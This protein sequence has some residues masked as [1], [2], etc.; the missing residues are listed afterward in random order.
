MPLLGRPPVR[1]AFVRLS[2]PRSSWTSRCCWRCLPS[3]RRKPSRRCRSV[4]RLPSP[5]QTD[6]D[7]DAGRTRRD[8][9]DCIRVGHPGP[10]LAGRWVSLSSA[11]CSSRRRWRSMW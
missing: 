8:P 1:S 7:D 6:H 10:R 11:G 5:L 4:G 3:G 2:G 9:A